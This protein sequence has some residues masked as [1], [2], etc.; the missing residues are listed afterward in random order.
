MSDTNK[1]LISVVIPAFNEGENINVCYQRLKAVFSAIESYQYEFIYIN[2]GSTDDT[3][4]II[5]QLCL[6]DAAIT[7]IVLSRNFGKEVAMTAGLDYS[8]GHAVFV[9]DADLQDPPELL[10]QFITELENG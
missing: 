9:I 3:Q 4:Q 7:S 10:P 2:D 8:K 5:N 1:K 6:Q